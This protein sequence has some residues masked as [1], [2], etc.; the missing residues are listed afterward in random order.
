M[1]IEYPRVPWYS[2]PCVCADSQGRREVHVPLLYLVL[3]LCDYLG[4]TTCEYPEYLPSTPC[5]MR[6]HALESVAVHADDWMKRPPKS[7]L[8][9]PACMMRR[10][11]ERPISRTHGTLKYRL[12]VPYRLIPKV[13]LECLWRIPGRRRKSRRPRRRTSDCNSPQ[14]ARLCVRVCVYV[15]ARC[16]DNTLVVTHLHRESI[17]Y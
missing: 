14:C 15:S 9:L 6:W 5:T 12:V 13:P 16:V 11:C 7:A 17:V 10:E 2:T 1:S 8:A 3:V 4:S